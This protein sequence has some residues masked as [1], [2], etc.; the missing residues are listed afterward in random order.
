ME[1]TTWYRRAFNI[2]QVAH[3]NRKARK[4]NER[5]QPRIY[6]QNATRSGT[7]TDAT[8]HASHQTSG[9]RQMLV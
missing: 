4:G 7:Y 3:L 5:V 2:S 9:H 6:T 1:S 8:F